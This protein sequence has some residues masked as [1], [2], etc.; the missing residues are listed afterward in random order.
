M[1]IKVRCTV[2]GIFFLFISCRNNKQL[3][4]SEY[5]TKNQRL[6]NEEI[7]KMSNEELNKMDKE[8]KQ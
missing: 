7:R 5:P 8:K 1:K 3:N 4:N 2:I 6:K